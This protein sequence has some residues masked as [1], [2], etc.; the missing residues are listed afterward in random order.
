V[1]ATQE[2]NVAHIGVAR[3]KRL[4]R[5]V[6]DAPELT[7]AVIETVQKK[8]EKLIANFSKGDQS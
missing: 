2:T 8:L 5:E 6:E 3:L 4:L 1:P 7:P